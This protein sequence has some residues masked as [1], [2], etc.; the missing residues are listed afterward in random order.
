MHSCAQ[1]LCYDFSAINAYA[2]MKFLVQ[3]YDLR[4]IFCT[5]NRKTIDFQFE[6]F[7]LLG[8]DL[9]F[10]KF[11]YGAKQLVRCNGP[12]WRNFT[13]IVTAV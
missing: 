1:Q 5:G 7:A 2:N 3:Y 13:K 12:A 6:S 10:C 11:L 4:M 9:T 8:F